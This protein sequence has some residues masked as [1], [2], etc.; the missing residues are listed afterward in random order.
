MV[1]TTYHFV[2]RPSNVP[3]QHPYL[4]FDG[5]D[6]LRFHLFWLLGILSVPACCTSRCVL[7]YNRRNFLPVVWRCRDGFFPF[8]SLAFNAEY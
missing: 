3:H 8:S 1:R 6:R 5:Q 2:P 4:V 7:C